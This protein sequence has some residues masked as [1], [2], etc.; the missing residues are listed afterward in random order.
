MRIDQALTW[1]ES[2][3]SNSDSALLDAQV[4]LAFVL[5][6]Q[7]IYLMTW[8]EREL[9]EQQTLGFKA[10][11]EQ[12][13][14]GIPVAHLTGEREFWSLPLKVNN[15]TL[16]PRP[17]TEI[18]VE[19]A[20]DIVQQKMSHDAHILDLGT[21]TGAIILA[22]ASELPNATCVAVD[23]SE[24][25]VKLA[26]ENVDNLQLKNVIVQQSNWFNNVQGR[27]DIIVSNPPYIDA[28][29]K[30]LHQGDVRFEPISAL[31]ANEQGLSDIR[32]ICEQAKLYL[33]VGGCLLF[34]HGFEQASAV[35]DLLKKNGFASITTHQDYGQNDRV[36]LGYAL[37]HKEV[38][39]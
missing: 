38:T 7:T 35:Q 26:L 20:L 10:L 11:I 30:H 12:R 19:V 36:T 17:D 5:D 15:S 21:G 27:F 18:L 24:E 28:D 32:H 33:K 34:E 37:T 29:D 25:A 31:V 2:T 1:A 23:K 14:K 13:I 3:L 4:L 9:T 6:K 22:L 16:I 8:P 39:I